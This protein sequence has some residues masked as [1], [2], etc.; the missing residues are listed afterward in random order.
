[1]DRPERV[2]FLV[3]RML[4]TLCRYLR[5]LGYDAASANSIHPG[6]AKEDS[7]LLSRARSEGRLLLTR[8]RELA[9]RAG[10]D[11]VLICEGDVIRQLQQLVDLGWAGTEMK[12]NRCSLCNTLLRPAYRD[13]ISK[14]RYAPESREGLNFFWCR[15]CRKL[16]WTGSHGYQI[17]QR[18][19]KGIR[20]SRR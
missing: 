16:Y 19:K 8:D 15:H 7:V 12:F 10:E 11:A 5:F 4:G 17:E 6:D 20:P 9:H 13:E 1:M 14:A 3:D 18:I 2:R